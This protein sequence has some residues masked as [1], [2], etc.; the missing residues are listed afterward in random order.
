MSETKY[1]FTS[2]AAPTAD[3]IAAWDALPDEEKRA[4]A[5]AELAKGM[6]GKA[7]PLTTE[8]KYRLFASALTRSQTGA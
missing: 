7:E 6:S 1:N 5:T 4:V 2:Y 3:D 8:L